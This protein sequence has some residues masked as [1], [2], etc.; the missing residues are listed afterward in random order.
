[1]LFFLNSNNYILST[2]C[3]I[4]SHI[5]LCYIQFSTLDY[6]MLH[7]LHKVI[8]YYVT[9]ILSGSMR[10]IHYWALKISSTVCLW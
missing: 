7:I 3:Y 4:I 8:V 6:I 1:M 2:S 9:F 5:T 10:Q